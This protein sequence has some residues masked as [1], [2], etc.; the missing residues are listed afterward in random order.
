MLESFKNGAEVAEKATEQIK[1]MH[2]K[3]GRAKWPGECAAQYPDTGAVLC[4]IITKSLV[5]SSM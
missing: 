2:A 4:S 1:G 3:T 5:K